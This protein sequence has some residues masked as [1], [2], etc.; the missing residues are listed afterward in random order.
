MIIL[1]PHLSGTEASTL[2]PSFLLS[3]IWSV[4]YIVGILS[5]WANIHLSVSA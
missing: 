5:F 2:W 4:S 1:F 3:F